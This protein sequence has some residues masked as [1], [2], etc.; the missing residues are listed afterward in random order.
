MEKNNEQTVKLCLTIVL[1]TNY[2]KYEPLF[3]LQSLQWQVVSYILQLSSFSSFTKI[4]F[5]VSLM[6]YSGKGGDIPMPSGISC[7]GALSLSKAPC[8]WLTAP[9][10]LTFGKIPPFPL[11]CCHCSMGRSSF[12]FFF[13]LF[14]WNWFRACSGCLLTLAIF[15]KFSC[16]IYGS[17]N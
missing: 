5:R 17:F 1:N 2:E 3:A 4:W 9:P 11:W 16:L 15:Q 7:K 10:F 13:L 6:G 14:F 12:F 8:T